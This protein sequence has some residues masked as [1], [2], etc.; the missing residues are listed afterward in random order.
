MSPHQ[1]LATQWRHMFIDVPTVSM[2]VPPSRHDIE[3]T[4]GE[5]GRGTQQ[6]WTSRGGTWLPALALPAMG[7]W[8]TCGPLDLQNFIFFPFTLE[9]HKVWQWLCAVASSNGT[10]PL[11]RRFAISKVRVRDRV[12][13]LFYLFISKTWVRVSMVRFRVRASGPS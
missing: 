3:S 13:Y 4:G 6:P 1:S 5:T 8:G 9:L 7:K 10:G 11:F 12:I 2:P